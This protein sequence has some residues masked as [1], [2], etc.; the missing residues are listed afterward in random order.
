MNHNQERGCIMSLTLIVIFSLFIW[1]ILF[2]AQNP[3]LYKITDE[4]RSYYTNSFTLTDST[5]VF[6]EYN[7]NGTNK[8]S[9]TLSYPYEMLDNTIP[10]K[11]TRKYIKEL[12]EQGYSKGWATHK[13][14]V[15][16]K[17]IAEDDMYLAI[18]ED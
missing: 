6:N 10:N 12:R 4:N 14:L 9:V 15:E 7:R 8:L 13:A 16:C 5:I 3:T 2:N 11:N 1:G 17:Q 18:Q